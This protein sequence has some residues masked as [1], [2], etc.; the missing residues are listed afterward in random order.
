MWLCPKSCALSYAHCVKSESEPLESTSACGQS[1][2]FVGWQ[3][4]SA[5]GLVPAVQLWLVG[6]GSCASKTHRCSKPTLNLVLCYGQRENPLENKQRAR[7]REPARVSA[8]RCHHEMFGEI[9]N[10]CD[11]CIKITPLRSHMRHFTSCTS[12]QRLRQGWTTVLLQ[13]PG[14][15][16]DWLPGF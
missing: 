9:T 5:S 6:M 7:S 1:C 3:D 2:V 11:L 4:V 15:C 16:V 10:A 8:A 13:P 14:L 12:V